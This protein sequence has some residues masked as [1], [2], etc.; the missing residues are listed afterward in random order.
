MTVI[1]TRIYDTPQNAKGAVTK[2]KKSRV[3]DDQISV[4]S[5]EGKSPDDVV[6]AIEAAGLPAASAKVYAEA[7]AKGGTLVAVRPLFGKGAEA[8][9]I[10]DSFSPIE[11][12]LESDHVVTATDP[13][14]P[15]SSAAGWAT[16]SNDP[17]P[18]STFFKWPLLSDNKFPA[19]K[20]FSWSLLSSDKFPASKLFSWAL[21][22][23]N[24]FPAS[25]QFNWPLLSSNPTPLSTKYNLQLLSD[26]ATPL[27]R[28]LNIAVLSK[29]P[30]SAG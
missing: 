13:T 20:W 6:A 9:E 3:K 1:S 25:K 19:S 17:T 28:K 7:V 22:S 12:S 10:L 4:V 18:L 5:S 14:A 23:D 30:N 16:L 2:L 11:T 24:K 15:L 27:S 8:N 29:E 21:L 26:D